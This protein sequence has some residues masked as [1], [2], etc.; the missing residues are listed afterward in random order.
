[1]TATSDYG[2]FD[3][4]NTAVGLRAD[5]VF[6]PDVAANP[7]CYQ[8]EDRLRGKFFRVGLRE[9]A[10]I[11][12]LDGRATVAEAV[13]R[14]AARLGPQALTVDE[15][16]AICRW[17]IESRL[18]FRVDAAA[19][20]R[21][22]LETDLARFHLRDLNPLG[23]R[24]PL[25][26]PDR[27]ISRLWPYAAWLFSWPA[28]VAA[29]V[30]GL[31]AVLR[32]ADQGS[33]FAAAAAVIFGPDQWPLMIAAWIL[34]KLVHET[35]HALACKKFGGSV[36]STG[37]MFI[38]LTPVA[39]VDVTSA[40]R[41]PRKWPRI[42]TASAGIYIELLLA[43]LAAVAWSNHPAGL[44]GRFCLDLALMGSV[45][46]L[47]FNAN[48]LV[49]FDAYFILSDLLGIVNLYSAGQG[50]LE[51]L[52]RRQVL[53]WPTPRPPWPVGRRLLV[54]GYG[55]GAGLWRLFFYLGIAAVLAATLSTL[56]TV[57]AVA[58]FLLAYAMPLVR[59]AGRLWRDRLTHETRPL[60]LAASAALTAGVLAA[61]VLVMRQP[62]RI[63]APAVVDFAPLTVVRARS[64]G[65]VRQVCVHDDQA[66]AA[67][68]VLLV[69]ENDELR[70]ELGDVQ[71]AIAQSKIKAGSLLQDGELAKYQVELANRQSL[72]KKQHE[73]Q[74]QVDELTI[75]AAVAGQVVA[76]NLEQLVGQYLKPGSE[77]A[78]IGDPRAKELVLAGAQDDLESF[79][80]QLG[81]PVEA[82]LHTVDRPRFTAA[83]AELRPRAEQEPPHPALGANAGGP[84]PVR[85]RP[86]NPS[87]DAA[88]P[89]RFELVEPCFRGSVPVPAEVAESLAAG[90]PAVVRFCS[91]TE[92]TWSRVEKGIQRWFRNKIG[93]Q[94]AAG[95]RG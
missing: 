21:P 36:G 3:A 70:H 50:W 79:R 32:V 19:P 9:F 77:I 8:I 10:L 61:A 20:P 72:E 7:P 71:L 91:T 44:A 16:L 82:T 34:L 62:G 27:L 40:W 6:T 81:R 33:A 51:G 78:V 88:E 48:P 86:R 83:L 4:G 23:I 94:P 49:R 56:G 39:F 29:L 18:G 54:A 63:T 64:P 15:A 76:R 26:N 89:E 35:G 17:L 73:I 75:R 90:T 13:G 11:G 55:L 87:D 52:V 24:L 68:A 42:V 43:A 85:V 80:A 5:L 95:A 38:L 60:R 65:F 58:L 14:T 31:Y 67:G 45:N 92:S 57:L 30:L 28:A 59:L 93:P 25:A 66:V 69:L 74:A 41:F 47:L 12:H 2:I 53:G 22:C 46:T 37:V 1:M 84:I